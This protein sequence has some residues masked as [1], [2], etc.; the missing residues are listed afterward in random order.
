MLGAIAVLGIIF[1]LVVALW[2]VELLL[3]KNLS[4]KRDEDVEEVDSVA[5]ALSDMDWVDAMR[6]I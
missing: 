4:R 3:S 1:L 5:I 2:F 6:T